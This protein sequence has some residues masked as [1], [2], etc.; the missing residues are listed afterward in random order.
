MTTSLPML[1]ITLLS[2]CKLPSD[3]SPCSVSD[4]ALPEGVAE[5]EAVADPVGVDMSAARRDSLFVAVAE[6]VDEA[7]EDDA[8]AATDEDE[9]A[10]ELA[11]ADELGAGVED[12]AGAAEVV[13][14]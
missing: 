1:T 6:A 11:G 9:A 7:A 4:P 8:D 2:I 5:D 3:P 14:G 13:G 12:V 10:T